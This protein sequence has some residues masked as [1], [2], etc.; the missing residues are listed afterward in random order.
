MENNF[1]PDIFSY[2]E[3][4]NPT[5]S[6][7]ADHVILQFYQTKESLTDIESYKRFLENAIA[8]FR[9]S[10]T[11]KNYKAYLM[12]LG[13]DCCQINNNLNSEMVTIEM[14]HNMLTI[15]DIA[16]IITEHIINTKGFISTFQLVELLKEEH[17]NNRV[18]LVMLSLTSHQLYH[19]ADLF[20]HPD[21]C[22]GDWYSFLSTYHTGITHDIAVKI[23]CYINKALDE[24]KTNH[25]EL[26]KLRNNILDWSK[27]NGN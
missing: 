6:A 3:T 25:G 13:L 15:F 21:M 10:K 16:L 27:Y 8:R 20:V 1:F 9:H 24:G 26:L 5:L 7:N 18:Q 2:D 19:G 4:F 23:L 11:Y 12:E 14:H 22:F 17:K